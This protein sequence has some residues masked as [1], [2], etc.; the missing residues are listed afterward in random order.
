MAFK[1]T[2]AGKA[3]SWVGI[4]GGTLGAASN[5]VGSF[6]PKLEDEVVVEVLGQP[7]ADK[8][9]L[10]F[11]ALA[12][13]HGVV[14][15][16]GNLALNE[17]VIIPPTA[18]IIMIEYDAADHWVRATLKYNTSTMVA[19]KLSP[20]DI[21]ENELFDG[22]A[23]YRGPSCSVVGGQ[24]D[25]KSPSLAGIPSGEPG[26]FFPDL[27]FRGQQILNSCPTSVE[28]DP[29]PIAN[30]PAP[31]LP[32]HNAGPKINSPNPKPPGDNRSRGI[33]I[34]SE[35]TTTA[36]KPPPGGASMNAAGGP[37][38]AGGWLD[39]LF[40]TPEPGYKPGYKKCCE[41]TGLLVGMVYSSLSNPGGHSGM[42]FPAPTPGPA[43]G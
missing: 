37:A 10:Y 16:I 3:L 14:R 26:T 43:G 8:Q 5:A 24:F 22:M 30:K 40:M 27:P 13:A 33:V 20:D 38:P 4:T 41:K 7:G 34:A 28:P 42:T 21:T 25:F 2:W 12:A 29:Y 15:R 35:E 39:S 11:L 6:S 31:T 32:L 1:D 23:V 36:V 9:N 18:A 19:S 17:S